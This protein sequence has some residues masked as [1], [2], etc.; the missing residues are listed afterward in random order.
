M[1]ALP[2]H[3][4]ILVVANKAWEAE[5]VVGALTSKYG[6]P[7]AYKRIAFEGF[8][9]RVNVPE[10][11]E[12]PEGGEK[13]NAPWPPR[14]R[15]SFSVQMSHVVGAT[16]E[17]K[18]AAVDVWC[19]EDWMRVKEAEVDLG[20]G[21]KEK[22]RL[23]GSSSHEKWFHALPEIK[24]RAFKGEA[25]PDIVIAL[26]TAGIP[27][28]ETL[29]GCVTLG[30]R[31]YVHDAFDPKYGEK[32]RADEAAR[33]AP[34]SLLSLD[35]LPLT[36]QEKDCRYIYRESPRLHDDLF[37]NLSHATRNAAEARFLTTPVNPATP[38][39]VL[40]GRGFA[41]LGTLNVT[42]YD[43]YVW[44]DDQ[45]MHTFAEAIRQREIGSME[46]THGLIRLT[47]PDTTFLFASG[48]TDV[49]GSFNAEVTPRIYGQNFVAAHNAGILVAHLVPELLSLSLEGK[50]LRG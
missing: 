33:V 19:I 6:P 23:S 31:V 13:R 15:L 18:V 3:L 45:S 2:V 42:N 11:P 50:V 22:R 26:G 47:W 49:V 8:H 35:D 30:S 27:S 16:A 40:A 39:R 41:S 24:K 14:A 7:D 48:L 1:S 36:E 25:P 37:L 10:K 32:D 29:N 4:R 38:P 5:P 9:P 34:F 17:A 21:K 46:T 20:A 44:A 28:N 43:D 12:L